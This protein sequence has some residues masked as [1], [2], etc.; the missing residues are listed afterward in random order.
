MRTSDAILHA[1]TYV[2]IMG[3]REHDEA[4]RRSSILQ[5]VLYFSSRC[6]GETA[7]RQTGRQNSIHASPAKPSQ[8][9]GGAVVAPNVRG[10]DGQHASTGSCAL[11]GTWARRRAAAISS[12]QVSRHWARWYSRYR[13]WVNR[14]LRLVGPHSS[15]CGPAGQHQP[16]AGG[17]GMVAPVAGL[18]VGCPRPVPP[19]G[20]VSNWL[21]GGYL[22]LRLLCLLLLSAG[23]WHAGAAAV[24]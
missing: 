20:S 4:E 5:V 13:R 3:V 16:E 24:R 11:P 15:I 1:L 8:T 12:P 21:S 22:V 6:T 23:R 19:G 14:G 17:S 18:V 7:P 9:D 10:G 2:C